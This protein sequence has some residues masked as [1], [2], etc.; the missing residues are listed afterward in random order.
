MCKEIQRKETAVYV[1]KRKQT[2]LLREE[3]HKNLRDGAYEEEKK[4]V[5][6]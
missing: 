4:E 3:R 1:P 5:V 6:Q 2:F